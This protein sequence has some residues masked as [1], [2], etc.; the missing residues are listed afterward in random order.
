MEKK[1]KLSHNR[2]KKSFFFFLQ[3]DSK[4]SNFDFLKKKI[5]TTKRLPQL[6]K[7]NFYIS[8]LLKL[9]VGI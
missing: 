5:P 2:F 4:T 8:H 3:L 1:K 6:R 7:E 9:I